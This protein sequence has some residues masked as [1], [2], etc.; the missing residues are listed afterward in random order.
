MG[1]HRAGLSGTAYQLA[2]LIENGV[3]STRYGEP[4]GGTACSHEQHH[5]ARPARHNF[6]VR[7]IKRWTDLKVLRWY[8]VIAGM[9][10]YTSET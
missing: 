7:G 9:L 6:L 3:R 2:N 4:Q 5:G 10:I 1:R 8:D